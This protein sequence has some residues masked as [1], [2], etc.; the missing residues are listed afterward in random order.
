MIMGFRT[1]LRTLFVGGLLA[2]MAITLPAQGGERPTLRA[3]ITVEG[4]LVTLGDLVSDAG[5]AAGTAVF[6]APDPGTTGTVS[7]SRIVAAAEGHGL[8]PE[9]DGL[10]TVTVSRASRAV[11]ADDITSQ[12]VKRLRA[13]GRIAAGAEADIRLD[14]F[15][16][17]MHVEANAV[18]PIEIRNLDHDPRSGRFS[19]D[20]AIADS[21]IAGAGFRVSG[22]IAELVRVPVMVR[23]LRRGETISPGDVA[24]QRIARSELRDDVVRTPEELVGQAA[25]RGLRAGA[26]V[27]ADSLMEPILVQ[28]NE[29]VTIVYRIP[30]LTLTARGRAIGGGSRGDMVTVINNQSNRTV[31]ARVTGAGHVTVSASSSVSDALAA[32]GL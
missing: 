30:G 6:R 32:A 11:A 15:A 8:S 18:A 21:R 10:Q 31:E 5:D 28:R 25:R 1:I 22:R 17:A 13:D 9:L 7:A 2:A 3:V 27:S 24:V 12:I 29:A 4:P 14:G 19:A 16:R 20:L 23:N 26:P